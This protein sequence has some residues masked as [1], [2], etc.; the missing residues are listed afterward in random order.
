[1]IGRVRVA[2]LCLGLLLMVGAGAYSATR[3]ARFT[4]SNTGLFVDYPG[5][6]WGGALA[7]GLGAALAAAACS[8]FARIAAA[9][10]A[11]ATL[12]YGLH[13]SRFRVAIED[14]GASERGLVQTTSIP[15]SQV[16]RV[17]NGSRLIVVWGLGEDHVRIDAGGFPPE[18]R[19]RLERTLARR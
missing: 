10:V 19:A 8:R 15:W 3:E 17:E 7:A 18:E 4:W 13:L 1:M 2:A 12:A 6:A 16:S 14:A 5:A 9:L 11:A